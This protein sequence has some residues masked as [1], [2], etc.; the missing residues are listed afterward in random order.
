MEG[1]GVYSNARGVRM[2]D[3]QTLKRAIEKAEAN[4]FKEHLKYLP[5]FPHYKTGEKPKNEQLELLAN[6]I[7]MN[8]KERIIF[9]HSFAKA[10]WKPDKTKYCKLCKRKGGW[11]TTVS[12]GCHFGEEDEWRICPTCD[13]K[14]KVDIRWRYHLQRMVVE[15][16]PFKYLGKFLEV[17]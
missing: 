15:E 2:T 8:Q 12:L 6:H 11:W 3:E 13:G 16:E 7:F 9:S 1:E 5:L 4:G 14:S 17:K 10:F